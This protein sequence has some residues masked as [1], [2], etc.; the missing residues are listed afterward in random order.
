MKRVALEAWDAAK[1]VLPTVT[2]I[3][4][5]RTLPAVLCIAAGLFTGYRIRRRACARHEAYA[6]QRGWDHGREWEQL[7]RRRTWT[8]LRPQ[9]RDTAAV[10]RRELTAGDT[11]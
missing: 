6:E 7:I 8:T 11:P 3:A 9:T 2:A 10:I 4:M 1:W 5:T